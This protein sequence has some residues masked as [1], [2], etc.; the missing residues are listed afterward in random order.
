MVGRK[1]CPRCGSEL[2]YDD[3]MGDGIV[4][5]VYWCG[6]C[7]WTMTVKPGTDQPGVS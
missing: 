5:R 2:D 4:F 3:L 7:E 1:D 6:K